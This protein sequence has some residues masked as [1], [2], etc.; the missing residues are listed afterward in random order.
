VTAPVDPARSASPARGPHAVDLALFGAKPVLPAGAHTRW[1]V[2]GD[3][4]RRAVARVLDRGILSGPFA[5]EAVAFEAE[6]AEFVG[7]KNE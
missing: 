6:F 4:E 5:P 7:A 1:P 3:E 2:V